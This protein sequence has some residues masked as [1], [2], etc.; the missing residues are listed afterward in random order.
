[1]IRGSRTQIHVEPELVFAMSRLTWND[2]PQLVPGMASIPV[3]T[4][5]PLGRTWI[6]RDQLRPENDRGFERLT[7]SRPQCCA[8]WSG[9]QKEEEEARQIR[10]RVGARS[11]AAYHPWACSCSEE[12]EENRL[13]LVWFK[14]RV[15]Y[16]TPPEVE[17]GQR[18]EQRAARSKTHDQECCQ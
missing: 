17:I 9:K 14:R 5:S 7:T 4:T 1:M 13:N 3:R 15:A 16:P 2:W 8:Q 10:S 11:G 18:K 6:G 12:D